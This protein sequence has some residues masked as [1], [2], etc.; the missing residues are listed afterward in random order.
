MTTTKQIK[1]KANVIIEKLLTSLRS[2]RDVG[3]LF[4]GY[5]KLKRNCYLGQVTVPFCFHKQST[6]RLVEASPVHWDSTN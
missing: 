5:L 6:L 3:S 2:G 4:I 1:K